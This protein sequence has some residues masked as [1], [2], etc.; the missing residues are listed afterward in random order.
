MKYEVLFTG[1]ALRD[2]EALPAAIASAVIALC[3]GPLAENPK[4]VGKPESTDG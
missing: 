2:L 4:R 1:G 3:D